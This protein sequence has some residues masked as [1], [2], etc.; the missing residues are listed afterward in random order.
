M[1][2]FK[3]FI[4]EKFFINSKV[5]VQLAIGAISIF[6]VNKILVERLGLLE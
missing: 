6:L 3:N 5:K 4:Y 2:S 1:I